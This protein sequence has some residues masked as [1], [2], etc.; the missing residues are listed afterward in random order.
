MIFFSLWEIFRSELDNVLE[1][2][3]SCPVQFG[4][5]KFHSFGASELGSVSYFVTVLL[6]L[7][8]AFILRSTAGNS[9]V[10]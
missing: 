8:I 5:K 7:C 2:V 9:R 10:C 1:N 4:D 3:G 6:C